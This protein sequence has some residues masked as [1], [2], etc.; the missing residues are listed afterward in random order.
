MKTQHPPHRILKVTQIDRLTYLHAPFTLETAL[1]L[2]HRMEVFQQ[3]CEADPWLLEARYNDPIGARFY[4]GD[5]DDHDNNEP[6][7]ELP[8]MVLCW[9]YEDQND[10]S[11]TRLCDVWW[12]VQHCQEIIMTGG[13]KIVDLDRIIADLS[14]N[15]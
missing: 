3:M 9:P 1:L 12:E 2:K 5:P 8:T 10:R 13:L 14:R 6:H 15:E 11:S 4:Y 7:D